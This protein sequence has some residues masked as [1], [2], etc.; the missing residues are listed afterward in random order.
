MKIKFN[1]ETEEVRSKRLCDIIEE[2]SGAYKQGS[3]IAVISEK[4]K[5]ELKNEFA[6][7][8]EVRE[9]RIKIVRGKEAETE[10]RSLFYKVYRKFRN[11]SGRIGWESED[12]TGIGPIETNLSVE[13]NEHRYRKWDVFF[14]FGGFDPGM[15]YLMI[16]KREHKAAYGT[17][18]DAVIGRLTRGRSI[19]SDLHEGDR[20]E[21][22]S[23]IVTKAER[24][25][26]VTSD[27]NTEIE[28][29][30]EIFTFAKVRLLREAA[31]SSEHFFSLT[32]DGIFHVDDFSHTY[33]A[34]ESFKGLS[35][36]VENIH[37]RSKYYLSVRNTGSEK[38]KVYAYKESRLPHPSH[39]VFGEIIQG[40]ELMDYARS[41]DTI[42]TVT[43]PK[44]MMVVGKSQKEAEEFFERENIEQ[45]R[46]GN[47]NDD[48]IVADLEPALTMEIVDRGAVRTVGVDAEGVF[49]VEL[50]HTEA[51]K[52]VWYFKKITGLINR[53]IGNLK[54]YFTAPGMMVLFHGNADEAGTLV[55]ENLPKEGVKKGILGVTN[56]SRSNRG[57]MGIR[58]N[59]S[60]EYGPTG[61]SFDGANLVLS[62]SSIT[63][64]KLSFLSKL[65]EGDVIYVKEK[66]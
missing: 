60:K 12:I 24:I 31:M 34:S 63:P 25:G 37:Y 16:S 51:P 23:P 56:M 4:E 57:I 64:S 52:T 28:E 30:Q 29:G 1:G 58:L 45:V 33:L 3:V 19:I 15:T 61:E 47:K 40:G 5:V 2:L 44:W 8:T 55:P 13:K 42:Y 49:E 48:A 43:E 11:E 54:V 22:I 59:D 14:G 46:E 6:I 18:A 10:A 66:A 41:G 21:E 65:K 7:K 27:L 53:P 17:D 38:G 36:P 20:I 39:S 9:A 32:R 26:F 62:L 50:Y 35:L